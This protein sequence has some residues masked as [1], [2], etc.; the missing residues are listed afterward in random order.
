MSWCRVKELGFMWAGKFETPPLPVQG[1]KGHVLRSIR[2][3]SSK[4]ETKNLRL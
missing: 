4:L 1:L 3:D 2:S